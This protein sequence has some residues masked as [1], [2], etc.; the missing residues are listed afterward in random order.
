MPANTPL[1]ADDP[2][3]QLAL[4]RP[5]DP[6]LL[7][8][9]VVGDT[10]TVLLSGADTNGRY[11]LI[12]MLIPAGGGPPPHRHDFEEMFHVLEGTI[13][14]TL[15]GVS[16]TA[17]AGETVNVPANAP[18]AFRNPTDASARL[19]CMVAPAGLEEFFAA[20]ADRVPSR[21]TPA[22]QLTPEEL[23]QRM[24]HAAELMAQYGIEPV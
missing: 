24:G 18:H 22:P 8:L 5:D 2:A 4:A 23:G 12:D 17:T 9:A 11:A 10:Y 16:A 7:H 14:V 20:F 19:L 15:R 1:P 3:R 13:E 21:T 6:D